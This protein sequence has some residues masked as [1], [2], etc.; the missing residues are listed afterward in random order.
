MKLVVLD[1]S[2][3]RRQDHKVLNYLQVGLVM[4]KYYDTFVIH[5]GQQ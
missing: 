5:L 3:P 2:F 4:A 1:L